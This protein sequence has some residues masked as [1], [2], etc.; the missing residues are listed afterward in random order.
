HR[1][2]QD[3]HQSQ[4]EHGQPGARLE[5]L[6]HGN[7]LDLRP[8]GEGLHQDQDRCRRLDEHTGSGGVQD[9]EILL[10]DRLRHEGDKERGSRVGAPAEVLHLPVEGGTGAHPVQELRAGR[11][12]RKGDDKGRVEQTGGEMRHA[13]TTTAVVL[14]LC[15]AAALYGQG[16]HGGGTP[17]A[18]LS[19]YRLPPLERAIL[20]TKYHEGW[21][22]E[23]KHW[24]YVGWGHHVLPGERLTNNITRAQGDS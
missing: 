11:P 7:R 18:A 22:G 8:D 6:R 17:S 2:R 23:K 1:P 14:L 13:R 4:R 24:P 20:C 3:L 5:N 12:G 10:Q 21:H 15:A 9:H 19:L 16:K